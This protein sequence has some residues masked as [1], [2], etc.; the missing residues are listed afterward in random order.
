MAA[1]RGSRREEIET[2]PRV[3]AW[4]FS[5]LKTWL[6]CP[7]KLKYS[8]IDKLPEPVSEAMLYGKI[9]HKSAEDFLLGKLKQLPAELGKFAE[10]YQ[11]LR[12]CGPDLYVE[13]PLT[14]REDLTLTTWFGKDAWLR[15]RYDAFVNNHDGSAV[16]LDWKTGRK[17]KEDIAQCE[18]FA[19][20]AFLA[21]PEL[22]E[23]QS[24]LWYL[25]S[26]ELTTA[27][28][29]REDL[30]RLKAKWFGDAGRML[31]DTEFLPTPNGLCSWCH[32]RKSNG[33]PCKF[34]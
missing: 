13:H 27:Q 34:S 11:A 22:T 12:N 33:G 19:I 3:Y 29:K 25:A 6:Q 4:S 14:F 17:R 31:T 9:I 1:F 8:A 7:A 15:V 16:L 30:E 18:L 21:Y 10:D 32:F 26:G 23:V 5:R 24:E 2:L 28:H 20:A